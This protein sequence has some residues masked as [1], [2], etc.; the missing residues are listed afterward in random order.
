MTVHSSTINKACLSSL[1]A[2]RLAD[3]M[4]RGGEAEV[5]IAGGMESM[6]NAPYLLLD[7]RS[8]FR[9]GDHQV[10]DALFHD[11]LTCAFDHC[12]MG[13]AT[14]NYNANRI[15]RARQDDFSARSHQLAA[16]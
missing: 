10:D 9:I 7:A 13:L 5:V 14:E 6:T 15:S 1:Q 3:L 8:G 2:L 11:G 4:I 16:A 12:A